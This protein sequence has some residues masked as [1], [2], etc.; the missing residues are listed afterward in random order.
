MRDSRAPQAPVRTWS[1]SAHTTP[2]HLA[3][4]EQTSHVSNTTPQAVPT[5]RVALMFRARPTTAPRLPW[6]VNTDAA[7][8]RGARAWNSSV[9]ARIS[10]HMHLFGPAR[11]REQKRSL[12][13]RRLRRCGSISVCA[14][15]L[16]TSASVG[17]PS[18]ASL[19]TAPDAPRQHQDTRRRC[20]PPQ[21][22][23]APGAAFSSITSCLIP[24]G[25]SA[26]SLTLPSRRTATSRA[27]RL[28]PS[29]RALS[30]TARI[31]C[32]TETRC[33]A[34][35]QEGEESKGGDSKTAL[36]GQ[37]PPRGET[38]RASIG[39]WQSSPPFRFRAPCPTSPF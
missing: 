23:R 28:S 9:P 33:E 32:A 10:R 27:A 12:T 1:T 4:C 3:R 18:T 21:S 6:D 36:S 24:Y 31:A 26:R 20:R 7:R 2:H 15:T 17:L 14:N 30:T 13:D 38:A 37:H 39:V 16:A 29:Q 34:A 8:S 19:R 11:L 35:C 5:E 25:D 22:G